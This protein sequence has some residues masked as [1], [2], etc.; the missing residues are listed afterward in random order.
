MNS[1]KQ[2][3]R[4]NFLRWSGLAFIGTI[5]IPGKSGSKNDK[6]ASV[7]STDNSRLQAMSRIRRAHGVVE[8]GAV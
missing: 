3:T 1:E 6:N 5:I 2:V 7:D 4:K 8:R